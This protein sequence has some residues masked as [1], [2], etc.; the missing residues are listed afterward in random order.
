MAG[1]VTPRKA[2]R[3]SDVV[4]MMREGYTQV[5]IA[6]KLGVSPSTVQK[7]WNAIHEE[8]VTA[9]TNDSYDKV[10]ARRLEQFSHVMRTAWEEHNN[11]KADTQDEKVLEAVNDLQQL[12]QQSGVSQRD[13]A[14]QVRLIAKSAVRSG[15]V[16]DRW[17][18]VVL[19]ALDSMCELEGVAQPKRKELASPD[20]VAD[21]EKFLDFILPHV[22]RALE[23]VNTKVVLQLPTGPTVVVPQQEPSVLQ[24]PGDGEFRLDDYRQPED[25]K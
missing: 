24:L 10:I 1:K 12:L 13:Y 2:L 21:S 5:A 17:L 20:T 8:M 6:E 19:S 23:M 22:K 7:D 15:E 4:V 9:R 16:D 3:R 25:H 11:S 18:R 14:K